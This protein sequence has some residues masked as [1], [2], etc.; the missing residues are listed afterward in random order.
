MNV[1]GCNK[2]LTD[3]EPPKRPLEG[4]LNDLGEVI[5]LNEDKVFLQE[6]HVS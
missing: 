6:Y 5:K 1:F 2:K 4:K 3:M